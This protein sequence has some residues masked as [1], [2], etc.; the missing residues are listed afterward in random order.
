MTK[1][2]YAT[3]LKGFGYL[4]CIFGAI[5]VLCLL[6]ETNLIANEKVTQKKLKQLN[7]VLSAVQR[8][9]NRMDESQWQ[10]MVTEMESIANAIQTLLN[11]K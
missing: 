5:T 8:M 11:G 3:F 10:A 4:D 2:Q 9:K 1:R 6:C 7:L